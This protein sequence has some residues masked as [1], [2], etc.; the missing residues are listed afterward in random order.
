[1]AEKENSSSFGFT[2]E[3]SRLLANIG[4]HEGQLVQGAPSSPALSNLVAKRLDQ[5]V[6]GLKKFLAKREPE[7]ERLKFYYSRYA[8][9]LVFS[10]DQES[11]LT[12]LPFVRQMIASEGFVVN[13]DKLRIMRSSRQQ[14]VTGYVVNES[15]NAPAKQYALIRNVLHGIPRNGIA[16]SIERWRAARSQNVKSAAHFRQILAGHIAFIGSAQPEK[17]AKLLD[18]LSAVELCFVQQH[19]RGSLV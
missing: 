11:L 18:A 19:G 15:L 2:F 10:S 14:K 1:L 4:C 7:G 17:A 9:D 12:I 5:R 8:D 3:V 13:E 6:E 16:A